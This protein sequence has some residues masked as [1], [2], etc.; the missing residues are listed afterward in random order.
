MVRGG[1]SRPTVWSDSLTHAHQ[2]TS[3]WAFSGAL[4]RCAEAWIIPWAASP[5][6]IARD[7]SVVAPAEEEGG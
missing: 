6:N 4:S 1:R 5:S 2:T 3:A 7:T